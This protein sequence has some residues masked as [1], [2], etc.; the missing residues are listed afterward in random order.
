[1][2]NQSANGRRRTADAA[3]TRV[4][5][6]PFAPAG[7]QRLERREERLVPQVRRR[8]AGGV[9]VNRRVVEEQAEVEVTL[10]HDEVALER[11]RV[12]RLLGPDEQPVTERG[13]T[14]VVLVIEERIEVRKV[15]WVVEEIHLRRGVVSERRR[16]AGP[17][18]KQ[19]IEIETK[20]DVELDNRR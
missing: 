20:G 13:E 2:T 11:R 12:D 16:I 6:K 14:T 17:V 5:N 15:P 8:Q 10:R 18:R 3:E 7:T 9:R 4:Q 1:M 19:R